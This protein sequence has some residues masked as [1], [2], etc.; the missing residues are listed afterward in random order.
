MATMIGTLPEEIQNHAKEME[1]HLHEFLDNLGAMLC[2]LKKLS[3]MKKVIVI[4]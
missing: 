2:V 1:K 4:V 3:K